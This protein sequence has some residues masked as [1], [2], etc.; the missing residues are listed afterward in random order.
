MPSMPKPELRPE[1][2]DNPDLSLDQTERALGDLE[3]VNRWLL[4]IGASIRTLL[5][6]IVAGPARQHLIDLGFGTGQVSR[7]LRQRAR[8]RGIELRVIGVDRKLSHL[9]TARARNAD[10]AAVVACATALPFRS[11]ST[12]WVYSHLLFHHFSAEAN[13]RILAEMVRVA[14]RATVIVDLRRSVLGSLL[15]SI[16]LP[17]LGLGPVAVYDGKLSMR[18]AW[19]LDEVRDLLDPASSV[20]LRR[21]FPVRFSLV[22][23][24]F[25]EDRAKPAEDQ[26][27]RL[28]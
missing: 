11:S 22:V 13:A 24:C 28:P 16:L 20:E 7:I 15:A 9:L 17:L 19:G 4:G 14:S 6:R 2:L 3:R 10:H 25:P 21:R 1:L 26:S 8:D 23:S 5:P 27:H 12:D 18:Q